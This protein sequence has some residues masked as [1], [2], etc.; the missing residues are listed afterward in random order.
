MME[1]KIRIIPEGKYEGYLWKSDRTGD[2]VDIFTGDISMPLLN[3]DEND[4]PFIVEGCLYDINNRISYIIKYVN[5]KYRVRK[6]ILA[7]LSREKKEGK[8]I[9]YKEHQYVAAFDNAPGYLCFREYWRAEKDIQCMGFETLLPSELV[10][11]G[12]KN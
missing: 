1:D 3:L 8:V 4:N 9:V 11:V 10:F 7:D 6:D 2:R 5:G 12:F